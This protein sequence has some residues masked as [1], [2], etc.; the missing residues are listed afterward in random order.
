MG[1]T[2]SC[3]VWA[4][5]VRSPGPRWPP[6]QVLALARHWRTSFHRFSSSPHSGR[7][8]LSHCPPRPAV[9]TPPQPILRW[10]SR[11]TMVLPSIRPGHLT[12]WTS[13]TSKRRFLFSE[14][15][16]APTR[17]PCWRSRPEGTKWPATDSNTVII[18]FRVHEQS[19]WTSQQQSKPIVTSSVDLPASIARLTA[20]YVSRRSLR[21][22]ATAWR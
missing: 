6:S 9:G 2:W 15:R 10:L 13:W 17:T 12:F 11:S 22:D 19:A 16:C 20:S 3:L 7:I 14:R 8:R 21:L 18:C 5:W 4:D 1:T